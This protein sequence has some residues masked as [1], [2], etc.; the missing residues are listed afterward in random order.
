MKQLRL[1]PDSGGDFWNDRF[2][3]GEPTTSNGRTSAFFLKKN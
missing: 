1:D 2:S 3:I